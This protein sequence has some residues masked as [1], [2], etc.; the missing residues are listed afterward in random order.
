MSL[1]PPRKAAL[2]NINEETLNSGE[3]FPFTAFINQ[4]VLFNLHMG[5]SWEEGE[6]RSWKGEVGKREWERASGGRRKCGGGGKSE[7]E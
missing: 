6:R 5:S 2:F 7:R 3:S 1:F 4:G